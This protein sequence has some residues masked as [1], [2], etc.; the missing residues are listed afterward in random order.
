MTT[1]SESTT[2]IRTPELRYKRVNKPNPED[3]WSATCDLY[4]FKYA[5]PIPISTISLD[6]ADIISLWLQADTPVQYVDDL[7]VIL[8]HPSETVEF[9]Q[10]SRREFVLSYLHRTYVNNEANRSL[11][12]I[13]NPNFGEFDSLANLREILA[14][15]MESPMSRDSIE[16]AEVAVS[17]QREE[18]GVSAEEWAERLSADLAAHKD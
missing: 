4:L 17:R 10:P 15:P 6:V 9:A 11:L 12:D 1:A 18:S 5:A 13:S 8:R 14:R 7:A 2:R 16:V 3:E